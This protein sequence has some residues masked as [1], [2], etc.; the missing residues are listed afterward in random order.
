MV[1]KGTFPATELTPAP[2]GLLGVANV[3][4]HAARATDE[5]WVR[6]YNVIFE[7]SPAKVAIISASGEE[8]VLSEGD[9]T[10]GLKFQEGVT[11]FL[12]EVTERVSGLGLPADDLEDRVKRQLEAV[13]Q[14]ALEFELWEGRANEDSGTPHHF[15]SMPETLGD[16]YGAAVLTSG[17]VP[18][19][20]A[21]ALLEGAIANSPTGGGG[22]IH[23]TRDVAAT[24]IGGGLSY[25]PDDLGG[26]KI[27][28][29]LG[30][31]VVVGSGYTGSGP[32]GAT[33]AA[34][35]DTNKWMYV[36]GPVD[37]HL[38]APE[39]LEASFDT[40]VNDQTIK[41]DRYA[42]VHFD[43]SIF[44]AAQVTLS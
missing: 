19:Q 6:G 36:T 38:T 30:T 24:I 31:P 32:E 33:G 22:V 17:G 11:P 1:F 8:E 29:S 2:C 13:T 27:I 42:S 35:S 43:P 18:A 34:P 7:T 37:V 28:T 44:Y 5:R 15:L 4:N 26:G 39:V 25:T 3:T 40:T 21:L 20:R 10:S 14:K 9:D 16:I 23:M 12:I 41:A